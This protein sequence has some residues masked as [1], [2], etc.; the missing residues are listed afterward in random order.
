MGKADESTARHA[1][2]PASDIGLHIGQSS[3]DA[4]AKRALLAI[5]D[6]LLR[7]DKRTENMEQRLQDQE[8]WTESQ[9]K[10]IHRV[11]W[12]IGMAALSAVGTVAVWAWDAARGVTHP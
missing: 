4:E 9:Q 11:G 12:V 6:L 2:T 7:I 5:S 1:K 8:A 3:L 10:I